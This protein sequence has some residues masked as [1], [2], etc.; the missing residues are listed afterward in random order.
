MIL[1]AADCGE[2]LK[3]ILVEEEIGKDARF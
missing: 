2:A 1:F 3:R